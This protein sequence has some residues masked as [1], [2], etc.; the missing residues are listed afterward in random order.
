MGVGRGV[1]SRKRLPSHSE[2]VW[3]SGKAVD[4]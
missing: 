2:P 4:W 1:R 3:P